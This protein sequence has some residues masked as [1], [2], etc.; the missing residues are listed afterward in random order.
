APDP[1]VAANQREALARADVTRACP[2][3]PFLGRRG[4]ARGGD[5]VGSSERLQAAAVPT[6]ARGPVGLE[7][8]VPDLTGGAVVRLD[9]AA[10][11]GDDSPHTRPERESDHRGG[12]PAGAQAK[13]R[14][15]ERTRVVD[16][17]RR[18]PQRRADRA[19]HGLPGPFAGK[20]RQEAGRA[21]GWVV[22][23]GY[24][25]SD[26]NDSLVA[27]DRLRT[28]GREALHHGVRAV[29]RR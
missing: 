29:R 17:E 11:N 13:L 4:P 24:P 5:A 16:Q 6:A 23:A 9:H 22:Q 26:R 3:D 7:R 8:L 20:V 1:E 28:D 18:Q 19:R 21:R 12:A 25:D 27:P 2:C 10:V 15:T 14:E